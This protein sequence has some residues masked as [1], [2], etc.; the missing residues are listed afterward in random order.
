MKGYISYER[1]KTSPKKFK[2]KYLG[3]T[4]GVPR[5]PVQKRAEAKKNMGGYI[6]VTFFQVGPPVYIYRVQNSKII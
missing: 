2:V 4:D 6:V 5:L 1:K 3:T